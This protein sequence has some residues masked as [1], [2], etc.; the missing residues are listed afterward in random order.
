[1]SAFCAA[2]PRTKYRSDPSGD[3]DG[4][5]SWSGVLIPSGSRLAFSHATSRTT[6]GTSGSRT[7]CP[8][9]HTFGPVPHHATHPATAPRTT[10]AVSQT[11]RRRRRL[12]G[13]LAGGGTA[14]GAAGG[15]GA[16]ADDGGD[17]GVSSAAG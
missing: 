7:P 11:R 13:S 14:G 2:L 16:A 3:T 4:S 17:G 8:S 10:A 6:F 5:Y 1:M 9:V 12:R 15:A